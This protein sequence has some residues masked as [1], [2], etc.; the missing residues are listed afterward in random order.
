MYDEAYQRFLEGKPPTDDCIAKFHTSLNLDEQRK[1]FLDKRRSEILEK[2]NR[3]IIMPLRKAPP[4]RFNEYED[5]KTGLKKSYG[6]YAPFAVKPT[7][8]NMRHY[9]SLGV[10]KMKRSGNPILEI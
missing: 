7:P 6:K 3:P 5:D 4:K 2:I 8:P 9:K 1:Y 10:S